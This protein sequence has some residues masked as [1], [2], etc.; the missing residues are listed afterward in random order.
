MDGSE[1][2]DF[3]KR[4]KTKNAQ[5][6]AQV[7]RGPRCR[8][9]I[10]PIGVES[11]TKTPMPTARNGCCS[12]S[13]ESAVPITRFFFW[14]SFIPRGLVPHFEMADGE[15]KRSTK[16]RRGESTDLRGLDLEQ[17]VIHD[18]GSTR[19]VRKF[20]PPPCWS[21]MLSATLVLLLIAA[22]TLGW[23]STVAVASQRNHK[24]SAQL[25]LLGLCVPQVLTLFSSLLKMFAKECGKKHTR[26]PHFQTY[27][28]PL[29]PIRHQPS[30]STVAPRSPPDAPPV[31]TKQC[32]WSRV[33]PL[34]A[35]E[36]FIEA[37]ASL[38]FLLRVIPGFFPLRF[39]PHLLTRG[40]QHCVGRCWPRF[41]HT[42]KH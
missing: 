1:P 21:S 34:L 3:R 39:F 17:I 40:V 10:N 30:S 15:V 13:T 5:T 36:A 22:A 25:L 19:Q 31:R 26:K 28:A 4:R 42:V 24:S 41:F 29:P 20:R 33:L 11:S 32:A 7:G 14:R 8:R 6:S 16:P 23:I 37:T 9:A 12:Q 35:L 27:G 18:A 38:C 2:T